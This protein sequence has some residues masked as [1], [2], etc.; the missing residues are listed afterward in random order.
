MAIFNLSSTVKG[1]ESYCDP[2][3]RYK[4]TEDFIEDNI[5]NLSPYG[6]IKAQK[7]INTLS[8]DLYIPFNPLV[9]KTI[10]GSAWGPRTPHRGQV[11]ARGGGKIPVELNNYFNVPKQTQNRSFVLG[12]YNSLPVR[13]W[14]YVPPTSSPSYDVIV[15]YHGTITTD[16][17]TPYNASEKFLNIA[18]S[19]NKLSLEDKIIFSV[20]YPQDTVPSWNTN[21]E[22]LNQGRADFQF[23]GIQISNF[24]LGDNLAYAEAALLWVM[25]NLNS[26]LSSNGFGTSIDKI[27]TFGHSQGGSLVHKL[28]TLYTIDG[29]ILNAPGPIDLLTTCAY[30]EDT[31]DS[32][33]SCRKLKFGFLSTD[34][35][36][37]KYNSISLINYLSGLKSPSLY[38]QALDDTTGNNNGAPQ[39]YN[40]QNILEPGLNACMDCA[41]FTFKYYD[42]G[43][44]EAFVTN[45][46]VQQDI[47]AFVGSGG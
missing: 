6:F 26:Y 23:P 29:V 38:I 44:H 37:D 17:I 13:G 1:L 34:I 15:L 25:N 5:A 11:Y 28:N 8:D 41:S 18:L 46:Q 35:E 9:Y 16:G 14:I 39:V 21:L 31:N 19:Q 47:R 45:S 43:G 3:F 40:M 10:R 22:E 12:S 24:Y 20:A 27:Y 33:F 36:P 42:T 2:I 7:N 4:V 30:S 32:I